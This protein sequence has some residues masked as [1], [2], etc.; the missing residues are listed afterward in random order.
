MVLILLFGVVCV[1]A[2]ET[3]DIA[4]IVNS[5]F[6]SDSL[7]IDDVREIYRSKLQFIGGTRIKAIDQREDQEIRSLF[8][9]EVM[10]WTKTDYTKYWMHLVFMEG[11]VPPVKRDDGPAVIRTVQGSEG[12]IG[13]VWARDLAGVQGVKT[14]LTLPRSKGK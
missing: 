6:P 8:L 5:K 10:H 7:S 4:I 3:D 12:S 9:D 11:A 1:E 13:Y 14:V 2:A